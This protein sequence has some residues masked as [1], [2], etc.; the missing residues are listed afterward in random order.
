M[1]C[2][3]VSGRQRLDGGPRLR[4]A[5]A[6]RAALGMRSL[7]LAFPTIPAPPAIPPP[8]SAFAFAVVRGDGLALR[9]RG[10]RRIGGARFLRSFLL[11]RFLGRSLLALLRRALLALWPLA[12]L[13][14]AIAS[15][16]VASRLLLLGALGLPR[17]L[18]LRL[19]LFAALSVLASVPPFTSAA[20][21]PIAAVVT[22]AT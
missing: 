16:T 7:P 1:H 14:P 3:V 8:A 17:W 19:A 15:V 20:F 10:D 9:D 6:L 11:A 21:A 4:L 2:D 13:L 18:L 5:R 22:L 12:L